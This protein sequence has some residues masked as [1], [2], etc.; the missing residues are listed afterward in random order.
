MNLKEKY[1]EWALVTGASSGIGREFVLEFARNGINSL[2]LARRKDRLLELKEEVKKQYGIE[3]VPIEADLSDINF[4]EKIEPIVKNYSIGILVNN[5]GFGS[6]GPFY[7][8][9]S[10]AEIK[11]TIVNCVAPTILTHK[12]LPQMIERKKGAIIFLGSIVGINPTPY[13]TVYSATKAFNVF[14]GAGLYEELRK[15]KLNI[16]VLTLNPGGT[17]TEFQR[18][19]NITSGPFAAYPDEVVKTAIKNLGKKPTTVHGFVNKLS[20]FFAKLLPLKIRLSATAK[21]VTKI[22]DRFNN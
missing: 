14:I 13:M 3:V 9:D 8:N 12:I 1:G 22:S 16:D 21:V 18:I 6:S 2:A 17:V 5:A 20:L 4:Y 11:M 15:L 10:N 7:K 19:S